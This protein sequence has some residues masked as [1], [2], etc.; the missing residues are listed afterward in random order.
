MCDLICDVN[1]C[2]WVGQ[3][4]HKFNKCTWCWHSHSVAD[5][6]GGASPYW[7]IFFSKSRFLRVKGIGYISFASE[8]TYIV[9]GG[10]LNSTHSLADAYI[11]LCALAINEDE[12]DK[13]SSVPFSKFLDLPLLPIA[14]VCL[15]K[16]WSPVADHLLDGNSCKKLIS[17]TSFLFFWFLI[18]AY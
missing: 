7:L 18:R 4:R 5:S 13:L 3:L 17:F 14:L 12:A 1:H 8:M 16:Q 10:A 11:S 2:A 6:R 9:L 15:S